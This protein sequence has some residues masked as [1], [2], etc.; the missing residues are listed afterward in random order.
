[1]SDQMIRLSE[2]PGFQTLTE[3]RQWWCRCQCHLF[4]QGVPDTGTSNCCQL[5]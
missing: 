5:L 1:M 4:R 2:S 3:N